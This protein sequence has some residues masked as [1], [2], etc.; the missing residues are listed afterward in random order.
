LSRGPVFAYSDVHHEGAIQRVKSPPHGL[1]IVKV[2]RPSA[3]NTVPSLFTFSFGFG[4]LMTTL[5]S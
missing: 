1:T 2:Q 4:L 5:N 3:M